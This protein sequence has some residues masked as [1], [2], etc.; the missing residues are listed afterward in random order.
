MKVK[1]T[2]P[3]E[4]LTPELRTLLI[5]G[6]WAI[7]KFLNDIPPHRHDELRALW[8]IHGAEILKT[9]P[10]GKKAW[11]PDRDEF[12]TFLRRNNQPR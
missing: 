4:A 3:A 5:E 9:L 1:S 7:G 8:A 6:P 2:A 11:F 10:K 12:V